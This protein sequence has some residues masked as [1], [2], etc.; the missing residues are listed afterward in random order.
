MSDQ[1]EPRRACDVCQIAAK[2][3]LSAED[4][5]DLHMLSGVRDPFEHRHAQIRDQLAAKAV[6]DVSWTMDPQGLRIAGVHAAAGVT[7]GAKH[8]TDQVRALAGEWVQQQKDFR[9][10]ADYA[11]AM[12]DNTAY[13]RRLLD[14]IEAELAA[15]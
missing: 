12:R 15:E 2:R 1:P 7:A 3:G 5:A 4:A 10:P 8:V 6:A 13:L 11:E 9:L 14:Q